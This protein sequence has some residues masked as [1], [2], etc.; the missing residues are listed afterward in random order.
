MFLLKVL[1]IAIQ[2]KDLSAIFSK[3]P[4]WSFFK[5][6]WRWNGYIFRNL[7][8]ILSRKIVLI[9][10]SRPHID[11]FGGV[12]SWKMFSIWNLAQITKNHPILLFFN[13]N[14]LQ[15]MRKKFSVRKTIFLGVLTLFFVQNFCSSYC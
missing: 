4:V 8:K 15:V 6:I 11:F 1:L 13:G 2:F 9:F 14:S 5:V 3:R 10:F 12:K 7:H